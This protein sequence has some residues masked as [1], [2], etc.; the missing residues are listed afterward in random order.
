MEYTL[1]NLWIRDLLFMHIIC[2]ALATS[3]YIGGFFLFYQSTFVYSLLFLVWFFIIYKRNGNKL[4]EL[5]IF[6]KSLIC[7]QVFNNSIVLICFGIGI[8]SITSS[9]WGEITIYKL[10]ISQLDSIYWSLTSDLLGPIVEE[11]TFRGIILNRLIKKC[12][13]NKA[14]IYSSLLFSLGHHPAQY[15]NTFI[16]SIILSLLYLG[17]RNL[18]LPITIHI[19]NNSAANILELLPS[20]I[21]TQKEEVLIGCIVLI[22]SAIYLANYIKNNWRP[23]ISSYK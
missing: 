6:F 1:H 16:F 14:I 22:P 10:P 4:S 11:I 15:M 19:L 21:F 20:D 17:S 7:K 13:V 3:G 18:L 5:S 8:G 9:F 2:L 23:I 12:G